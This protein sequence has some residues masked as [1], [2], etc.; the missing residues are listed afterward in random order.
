[1]FHV[2]MTHHA[3]VT[4][5]CDESRIRCFRQITALPGRKSTETHD[6]AFAEEVTNSSHLFFVILII[7]I[8]IEQYD[9]NEA[10]PAPAPAPAPGVLK[11]SGAGEQ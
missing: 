11:A 8:F 6:F 4:S 10:V 7:P 2:A 1:M 5:S 3:Q 9:D